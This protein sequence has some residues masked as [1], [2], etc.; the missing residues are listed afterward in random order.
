MAVGA[1]QRQAQTPAPTARTASPLA[2]AERAPGQFATEVGFLATQGV[3]PD[4]LLKAMRTA[5]ASG[6]FADEALLAQGFPEDRFY[7]LLARHLRVPFVDRPLPLGLASGAS[8]AAEHI[9]FASL[10]PNKSG[11]RAVLAPRGLALRALLAVARAGR[12]KAADFAI[13]SPRRFNALVRRRDR[14]ALLRRASHGLA[15]WDDRLSARTGLTRAQTAVVAA[16]A[17]VFGAGLL[18]RADI[19]LR[20]GAIALCLAFLGAVLVRLA[21]TAMGGRV[22]PP[23][24]GRIPDHELPVY[25][26][27]VPLFREARVLPRLVRALDALDYPRVKLD[28]KFMLE[29]GDRETIEAIEALHLP[30]RYEAIVAPAGA[31]RTKPRALNIAL[32]YARGEL[33]VVYDAEDRPEPGQLRAAVASFRA[34]GR[35]TA[36]LQAVL[37]IDH[38]DETWLTRMFALEYAGLFEVLLP[39]LAALNLP[40]P[41]GGTSNHF[42]VTAL[43]NAGGWDAWNVTEDVDLGYRLARLGFGVGSLASTTFEEAPLTLDAWIPQ[44]RRWLKGWMVTAVVVSRQPVRLFRELGFRGGASV[45]C[46][47]FGTVA[48]GL[49]GPLFAGAVAVR[50]ATGTLFH[51]T[52]P[53]DALWSVLSALLIV[54]GA[55][56]IVW[57]IALGARRGGRPDLLVWLATLPAYLLLVSAAAW[58]AL[59][60]AVREPHRWNKTEHG[61]AKRRAV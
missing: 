34:R 22:P 44:R 37:A 50:A 15:D 7:R 3:A 28:I 8:A 58:L 31:P 18:W 35:G 16:V 26:V 57:P 21:A 41:L 32:H 42:R 10:L 27:V 33:L 46:L 51:P 23:P 30:F 25:T 24:S 38:A 40:V 52:T 53:L 14:A 19:T 29:A 49:F 43:R 55:A 54:F 6:V 12:G 5:S 61:L 47:L 2:H 48:S 11:L 60:E 59:H 17:A 45:A 39:G 9:G 56:G 1:Q 13:A 4:A 36:C 20:C